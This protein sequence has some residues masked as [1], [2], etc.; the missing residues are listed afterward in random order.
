MANGTLPTYHNACYHYRFAAAYR[1]A[2]LASVM[3]IYAS[4]WPRSG[5][6]YRG[7]TRIISRRCLRGMVHTWRDLD[8]PRGTGAHAGHSRRA[9]GAPF[10]ACARGALP[11][12]PPFSTVLLAFTCVTRRAHTRVSVMLVQ[13]ARCASVLA[14]RCYTHLAAHCARRL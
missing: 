8:R 4:L 5:V 7:Q 13:Y 10:A 3:C 9:R 6:A 14:A 12:P 11:S 1:H 2:L